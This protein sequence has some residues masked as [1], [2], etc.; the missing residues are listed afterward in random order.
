MKYDKLSI[1]GL[2]KTFDLQDF[3]DSIHLLGRVSSPN[4]ILH[5]IYPIEYYEAGNALVLFQFN[6]SATGITLVYTPHLQTL[7]LCLSP[8]AI[9]SDV[10]LYVRFI[11]FILSK[12]ND[13]KL[14]DADQPLNA[15]TEDD[16]LKMIQ[17]HSKYLEH[18][19][20]TEEGFTMEGLNC[21]FTLKVAHLKPAS[22]IEKQAAELQN[23][24]MEMQWTLDD[25]EK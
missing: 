4:D 13:A 8:W 10:M 12:F 24:F 22:S 1:T 9:E 6:E 25:Y 14:F 7:S 20:A 15:L 19:L 11:N 18:L 21:N 5:G 2:P 23:V 17:S 3:C 16:E